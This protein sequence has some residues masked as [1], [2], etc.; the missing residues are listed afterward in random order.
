MITGSQFDT[1]RREFAPVRE[2]DPAL[3]DLLRDSA[4]PVRLPAGT[5]VFEE[6]A[7]CS[8]YP[9]LT[10]GRIRVTKSAP[11]GREISLY[12]VEPG[13]VCV[14]SLHCMVAES[15]FAAR[16][17]VT[18]DCEGILIP[19]PVFMRLVHENAAFRTWAFRTLAERILEMMEVI[20][21][22]AFHRLDQRLARILVE[23]AEDRPAAVLTRTHQDFADE[24]GSVREIVS[25]ILGAFADAGFV[26]LE[27]GRVHVLDPNGLRRV[28][29]GEIAAA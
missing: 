6:G 12:K 18:Q 3:Q 27:R 9:M 2:L 1:I 16:A 28:S 17:V 5:V 4:I 10:R 25:R 22:V 8:A 26:R 21:E 13:E 7:E 11:N 19:Q 20:S 29:E 24:L 23:Q 15:Y 14:L